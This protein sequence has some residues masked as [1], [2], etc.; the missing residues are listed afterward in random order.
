MPIRFAPDGFLD[1]ASD[2]SRLPASGDGKN[3]ASGAMVRCTNLSLDRAGRAETR[4]GSA[5]LSDAAVSNP[6]SLAEHNGSRIIFTPSA[7]YV[8]G[9]SKATGLTNARWTGFGYSA[10]NVETE[11]YFTTNGVDRKRITGGVVSEW[12]IAAPTVSPTVS[13]SMEVAYGQTWEK[14]AP[15]EQVTDYEETE[16]YTG[17]Q[18]WEDDEVA[19]EFYYARWVACDDPLSAYGL[20]SSSYWG[21]HQFERTYHSAVLYILEDYAYTTAYHWLQT[22]GSY[23]CCYDWERYFADGTI[24]S[25]ADSATYRAQQWYETHEELEAAVQVSYTY[26]RK[27][28]TVLECESNAATATTAIIGNGISVTWTASTDSQVTHVRLYRTLADDSVLYYAAE[29]AVGTTSTVL[30]L[31]DGTLGTELATD[32]DRLPLGATHVIGPDYDGHCFAAVGNKLYFCLPKQPEYWPADHY[33]EMFPTGQDMTALCL[34]NGQVY[35]FTR[36]RAALLQGTTADSFFP[37]PLQVLGGAASAWAVA[38]SQGQGVYHLTADGLHL[39]AGTDDRR[40]SDARFRPIF[41]GQTVG[42]LP[43]AS[44]DVDENWWVVLHGGKLYVGYADVTS[45]YATDLL[46]LNVE[47]GQVTPYDYGREF[48]YAVKDLYSDRLLAVDSNG[49]VREL[50]KI[51]ATTDAGTAI[52]WDLQSKDFSDSLRRYFP[53]YARWDVEVLSGNA[54]G[55]ILLEDETVQTHTLDERDPRKRHII[56]CNGRRVAVRAYGSGSVVFHSVEVD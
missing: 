26:C 47:S 25:T 7:I 42:L 3:E 37:L 14:T 11:S 8:D 28:G 27:S 55:L 31:D 35:A 50:E 16:A 4:R 6:R 32:H 5:L 15:Y 34:W 30:P 54:Y 22:F 13:G 46:V 2:P 29:F 40:L 44:R 43:G 39:L 38:S 21:T 53:R 49:S 41:Q 56:G 36:V 17:T 33:V 18:E 45:S 48:V 19:G 12:G 1:V 24:V 10:Y 9:V 20:T 23:E 51:G 52:A